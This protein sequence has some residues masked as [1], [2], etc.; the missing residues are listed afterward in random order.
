MQTIQQQGA[1]L[2]DVMQTQ[3]HI[4]WD[5]QVGTHTHTQLKPMQQLPCPVMR[6]R[7]WR[8]LWTEKQQKAVAKSCNVTVWHHAGTGHCLGKSTGS[9]AHH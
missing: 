8:Q 6:I 9:T 4:L 5:L 7:A 2:S 1:D 3:P